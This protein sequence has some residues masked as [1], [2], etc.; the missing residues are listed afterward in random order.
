MN[1][2]QWLSIPLVLIGIYVFLRALSKG[3]PE[4]VT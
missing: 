4:K 3:S 2:G 1:M